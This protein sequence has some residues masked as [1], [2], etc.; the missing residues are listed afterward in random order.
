M[1]CCLGWYTIY[2][3][4]CNIVYATSAHLHAVGCAYILIAPLCTIAYAPLCTNKLG[5]Q[6]LCIAPT[7]L[8]LCAW[9]TVGHTPQLRV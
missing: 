6:S 9:L 2:V 3:C 8:V 4:L 5:V 7:G 1:T